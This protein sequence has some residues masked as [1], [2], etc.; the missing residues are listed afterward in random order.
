MVMIQHTTVEGP[1]E[2]FWGVWERL[3]ALNH[4][5]SLS[6]VLG[7]GKGSGGVDDGLGV[8]AGGERGTALCGPA[9]AAPGAAPLLRLESLGNNVTLEGEGDVRD[10]M[11]V[12]VGCS[13]R[14]R[15]CAKCGGK[16]GWAVRQNMLAKQDFWREPGLFTCTID[17]RRFEGPRQAYEKVSD[18]RFIWRLMRELGVKR[19]AWALEFQQRTG[20]GWPHWHLLIDLADLPGHRLDLVKA[21]RLWRDKWGLGGLDLSMKD[22]HLASAEHA[23]MYLTKYLTKFPE[24]GFPPWVMESHGIRFIQGCRKL[25]PLV[26]GAKPKRK[27][28]R[29]RG[30]YRARRPLLDRMGECQLRSRVYEVKV[31]QESGAVMYKY[32][33]TLPASPELVEGITECHSDQPA[34]V[35][36]VMLLGKQAFV[37]QSGTS[38]D[39]VEFFKARPRYLEKLLERAETEKHYILADNEFYQRQM[40]REAL[41]NSC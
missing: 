21:W 7:P 4:I 30:E 26:S 6:D 29:E 34:R 12:V 36:R 20:E 23:V 1:Q 32:K 9:A 25:G 24:G 5:K 16:M 31:D 10:G 37:L 3:G 35:D 39:L 33:A 2:Q 40:E 18:G 22:V 8:A 41:E 38:R 15:T 19:W 28:A 27:V 14:L 13:C 11:E 17:R